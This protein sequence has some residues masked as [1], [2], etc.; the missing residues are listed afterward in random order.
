MLAVDENHQ[1]INNMWKAMPVWKRDGGSDKACREMV[2]PQWF[3]GRCF[4]T[5][6][7]HGIVNTANKV[8]LF[9][10]ATKSLED[11]AGKMVRGSGMSKATKNMEYFAHIARCALA[12][13]NAAITVTATTTLLCC[14]RG[15]R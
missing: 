6:G 15:G 11:F 2:M 5:A 9:H 4:L 14:A 1:P 10:Y 12:P 7:A 3:P 8:V 13:A